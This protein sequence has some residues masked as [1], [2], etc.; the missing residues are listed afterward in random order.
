MPV[1]ESCLLGEFLL[2]GGGGAVAQAAEAARQIRLLL[3]LDEQH[4]PLPRGHVLRRL[5]GEGGVVADG[6]YE[7]AFVLGEE[8]LGVVFDEHD[9]VLLAELDH[10][11]L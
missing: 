3:V 11:R 9:V 8:A 1:T 2:G 6:S 5:E 7:L 4:A 10:L